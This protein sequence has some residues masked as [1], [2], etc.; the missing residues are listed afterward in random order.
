[1]SIKTHNSTFTLQEIWILIAHFNS[2]IFVTAI[3]NKML[4]KDTI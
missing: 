2:S 3:K 1:M 4:D